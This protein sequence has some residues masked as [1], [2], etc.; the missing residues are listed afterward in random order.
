MTYPVENIPADQEI[1]EFLHI[2]KAFSDGDTDLSD[3]K[4]GI[5]EFTLEELGLP[6]SAT[7]LEGVKNIEKEVGL[8][9]WVSADNVCKSYKG[10]SLTY[11]RDFADKTTSQYHQGW[12]SRA[13]KDIFSRKKSGIKTGDQKNTYYDTYGFRHIHPIVYENLK[14]VF[15]KINGAVLRSRC[16]YFFSGE[17]EEFPNDD[18]WHIDEI[19]YTMLRLVIPVK[20]HPEHVMQFKL[21]DQE[22]L[23]QHLE[24][25]HAYIWDQR[26]PHRVTTKEVTPQNDPRI[27]LI[28]GFSP[29]FDYDLKSDTFYR[30][31]NFGMKLSDLVTNKKFIK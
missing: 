4:K 9:G 3:F 20:S 23:E 18:G 13:V 21:E 2:N 29:W 30:N 25:D 11:N 27:H 8:Q 22:I 26:A 7:L 14:G 28:F 15:D 5:Y 1:L 31:E 10:F 16:A 24:L 12:G 19:Q 17:L 6:D